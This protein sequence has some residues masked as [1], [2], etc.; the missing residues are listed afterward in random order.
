MLDR[1]GQNIAEYSILIALVIAAA[2]AMNTYVKRNLQAKVH[3]A[4]NYAGPEIKGV[5]GNDLKFS[6][7]QFEPDYVSSTTNQTSTKNALEKAGAGGEISRTDIVESSSVL[8]KSIE[9][10]TAPEAPKK[11]E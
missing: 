11:P 8:D 2:V 10:I 9:T 7:A 1:K 6:G 5:G 3:D 4:V